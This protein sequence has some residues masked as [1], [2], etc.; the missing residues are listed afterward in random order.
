MAGLQIFKDCKEIGIQEIEEEFTLI[1]EL[2][3]EISSLVSNQEQNILSLEE[4]ISEIKLNSEEIE[5]EIIQ[6]EE[7]EKETLFNFSK[8][9]ILKGGIGGATLGLIYLLASP[10]NI[11]TGMVGGVLIGG[12]SGLFFSK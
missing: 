2:Y 4:T 8:D 7:I 12:I 3:K 1:S 9:I 5:K 10:S 11:L 6:S